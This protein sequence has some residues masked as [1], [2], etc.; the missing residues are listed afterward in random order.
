MRLGATY[1]GDRR[2]TFVVWAPKAER[3]ELVRYDETGAE[4]ATTELEARP[5]GYFAGIVDGARPGTRYRYRLHRDGHEPIDRADPASRWQP[6]GV[7]GPSAVVDDDFDWSDRGWGGL[8][9]RAHVI[10]ELHVGTFTTDGTFDG[11]IDHLDDLVELGVTAV[12]L[13]PLA[14]FSGGRNWGYDGV[15]PYAAQDT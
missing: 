14:Q 11:V 13:M 9:L 10:Y 5:H 2:T 3:V 1:R 12:E 6:D 8:P 7:H 4:T 15:L